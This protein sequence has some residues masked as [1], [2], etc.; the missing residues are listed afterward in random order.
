MALQG[1]QLL[2]LVDPVIRREICRFVDSYRH[3]KGS[4]EINHFEWVG[5][6]MEL[7]KK[8]KL[9]NK[10][11][12]ALVMA[13]YRDLSKDDTN[14]FKEEFKIGSAVEFVW[15]TA[16]DRYGL[17]LRNKGCLSKCFPSCLDSVSVVSEKGDI[18][19]S[20]KEAKE[21]K[22]SKEAKDINVL[23]E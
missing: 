4:D 3:R 19:V 23:K 10:E 15:N 12:K 8:T 21:A 6:A 7:M 20:V 22:E 1:M 5:E 17:V 9:N 16:K 2:D 18:Q 11:K 13:L 14:D